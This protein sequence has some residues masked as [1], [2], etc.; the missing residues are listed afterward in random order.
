[1]A[2]ATDELRRARAAKCPGALP[3]SGLIEQEAGP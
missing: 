3:A 2:A 1:M